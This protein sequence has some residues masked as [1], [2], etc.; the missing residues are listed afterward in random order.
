MSLL[1]R[2]VLGMLG[3]MLD[4][5]T[6][7]FFFTLSYTNLT[8]PFDTEYI[9]WSRPIIVFTPSMMMMVMVM[10]MMVMM[11]VMLMMMMMMIMMMMMMMMMMVMMMVMLMMMMLMMM[12]MMMNTVKWM[13]VLY[14]IFA[15]TAFIFLPPLPYDYITRFDY[16][17]TKLLNTETLTRRVTTIL[18]STYKMLVWVH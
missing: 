4:T 18:H 6:I 8:Q 2:I 14:W 9:V 10:V 15:L 5:V 3:L 12:M 13:I 7:W 1:V 11:I 16:F 17:P